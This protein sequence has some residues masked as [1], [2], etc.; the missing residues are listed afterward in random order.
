MKFFPNFL[1]HEFMSL[2]SLIWV[3]F[4]ATYR[5]HS[6]LSAGHLHCVATDASSNTIG[7]KI[8]SSLSK[9]MPPHMARFPLKVFQISSLILSPVHELQAIR[10][11]NCINFTCLK[12]WST[13][14]H[15]DIPYNSTTTCTK[16]L[17]NNIILAIKTHH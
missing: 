17:T 9:S 4:W 16:R 6:S 8:C 15:V 12:L 13:G 2:S 11:I 3:T 10:C 1:S 5:G 7:R 14:R